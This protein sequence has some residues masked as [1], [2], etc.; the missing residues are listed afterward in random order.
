MTLPV[1]SCRSCNAPVIWCVT[2]HGKRM[3]VDAEPQTIDGDFWIDSKTDPPTALRFIATDFP[4][5]TRK[6]E[7]RH[8]HFVTCPDAKT[9]RRK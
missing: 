8:A 2:I 1:V 9:W 4:G 3:P 7:R 5:E 6:P